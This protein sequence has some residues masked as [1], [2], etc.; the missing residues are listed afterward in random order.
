M[1]GTR[2]TAV[3]KTGD[4]PLLKGLYSKGRAGENGEDRRHRK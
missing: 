3:N 4:L 2:V 1:P